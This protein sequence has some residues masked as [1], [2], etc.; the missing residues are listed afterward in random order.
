[1]HSSTKKGDGEV[2]NERL[3]FARNLWNSY[4]FGQSS[5]SL[6]DFKNIPVGR[7]RCIQLCTYKL[8]T[9]SY[10]PLECLRTKLTLEAIHY[11]HHVLLY[12]HKAFTTLTCG[13][14]LPTF[15]SC[16]SSHLILWTLPQGTV[17]YPPSLISGYLIY[18]S[19]SCS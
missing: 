8:K 15:P 3:A 17:R 16:D 6:A 14:W 10:Q 19:S 12:K 5:G 9:F 11:R 1:M 7:W 13:V 18:L 2:V 4:M